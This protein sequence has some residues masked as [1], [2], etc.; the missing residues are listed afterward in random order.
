ME[1][2]HPQVERFA[3]QLEIVSSQVERLTPQPA[4]PRKPI[5]NRDSSMKTTGLNRSE[6]ALLEEAKTKLDIAR[7]RIS[8]LAYMG[9][10]EQWLDQ[11]QASITAYEAQPNP[12][13]MLRHQK[14]F[15]ALKDT[16]LQQAADWGDT[17][18]DRCH[19][20]F[21]SSPHDP[22]PHSGF[23]AAR[24]NESKM[25]MVLP[26]LIDLASDHA[27]TLIRF[28]QPSDYAAKGQA[29]RDRLDSLNREQEKAKLKR[30]NTTANRRQAIQDVHANLRY[31]NRAGLATYRKQPN[32]RAL[33]R[34]LAS[35]TSPNA[36]S[37]A[38]TDNNSQA[39]SA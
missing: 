23:R 14:A 13:T 29:L 4:I 35:R 33:F 24:H 37:P 8:D 6:E 10:T 31:L 5:I 12:A 30:K 19:L 27:S 3:P 16:L 26:A 20:A 21:S 2:D 7:E 17:L 34:S 11:F 32:E 25:L 22:F 1:I 18:R 9:I 36:V 15:T 38:S 28:G 39:A